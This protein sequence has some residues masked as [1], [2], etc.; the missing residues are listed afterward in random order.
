MIKMGEDIKRILKERDL[1]SSV[2]GEL[3]RIYGEPLTI[4][5]GRPASEN[6]EI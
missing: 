6:L 1:L 5:Y 3:D 2:L 4:R